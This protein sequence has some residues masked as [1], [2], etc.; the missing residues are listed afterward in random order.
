MPGKE[1]RRAML[2]LVWKNCHPKELQFT[3]KRDLLNSIIESVPGIIYYI[4]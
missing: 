4:E 2:L 3:Q 1:H